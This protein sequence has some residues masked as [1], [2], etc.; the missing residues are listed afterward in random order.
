MDGT[1]GLV[2]NLRNVYYLPNSP[3]NLVSLGL[4][5]D[6]GIFH[7]NENETLFQVESRQILAQAQRWRNSYLLRPLNLSDNLLRIDD[8]TYRSPHVFQNTMTPATT[9]LTTWHKRLGHTNFFSLKTF[10]RHL[11]IT[12]VDDSKDYIC[13]SCQRAK[14]TK[15]YNRQPQSRAQRPY[16]FVHTD[17]VGPINPVGFGGERYFFT[18]TDDCTR[19]TETYTGTIKSDWLKYTKTYHSLCSTRSRNQHPIE[20]LRS[21]YGSELQSHKADDWMQKEGITFEPSAP[22]SQEQNRVSE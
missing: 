5:N 3:C 16:Q 9:T 22:Y 20:R 6:S 14:A 13:D 11:D 21:D 2:L 15:V 1:E 7:D 8:Q 4:L 17:L 12:Y 19:M 10:L 18:F